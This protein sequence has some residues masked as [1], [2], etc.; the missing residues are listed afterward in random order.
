[1]YSYVLNR[2]KYYVNFVGS[3]LS[4]AKPDYTIEFDDQ[5]F[6]FVGDFRHIF[7]MS[8]ITE[9]SKIEHTNYNE[10]KRLYK[11]RKKM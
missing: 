5:K 7:P 1:M 6:Q 3:G 9:Y 10:G 4:V 11:F 8:Q 2:Y